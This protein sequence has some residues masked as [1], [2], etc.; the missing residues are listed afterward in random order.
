MTSS[1]PPPPSRMLMQANWEKKERWFVQSQLSLA[2]KPGSL[3]EFNRQFNGQDFLINLQKSHIQSAT[4]YEWCILVCDDAKNGRNDRNDDYK[5][6]WTN[7][8]RCMKE[9][10]KRLA[11]QAATLTHPVIN[12]KCIWSPKCI[13]YFAASQKLYRAASSSCVC[14]F[15]LVASLF[16]Y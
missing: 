3:T 1:P 5:R 13:S 8:A 6:K 9:W 14:L 11:L 16:C 10:E 15:V 12:L 4:Q 7:N 2:S